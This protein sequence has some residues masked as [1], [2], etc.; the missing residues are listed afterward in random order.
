MIYYLDHQ[1]LSRLETVY[2]GLRQIQEEKNPLLE[3][4]VSGHDEITTLAQGINAAMRTMADLQQSL[5]DKQDILKHQAMHDTLTNL[6]NRTYFQQQL[7]HALQ[8]LEAEPDHLL[9]IFFLD[10]DGFKKINDSFGH[11]F[12]DKVLAQFGRL[13]KSCLRPQ[14]LIGRMGGDEFALI[15]ERIHSNEEAVA[16]AQRILEHTNVSFEVDGQT[17]RLSMSIGIAITPHS[18]AAENLM[19][20][21]DVAMYRAKQLGKGRYTLYDCSNDHL[22]H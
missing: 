20:A 1:V 21:A 18:I 17:L 7:N 12:G 6:P 2:F 19:Q 10:L 4:R 3:I 13:V 5:Q 11:Q 8:I 9:A 14:E 16:I 15:V 22:S